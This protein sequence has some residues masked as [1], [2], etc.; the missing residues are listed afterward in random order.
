MI[1]KISTKVDC[2]KGIIGSVLI[3]EKLAGQM[4]SVLRP[5][6]FSPELRP[7]YLAIRKLHQ[8]G[9]PVDPLTVKGELS[10]VTNQTLIQYLEATPTTTNFATYVEQ[11]IQQNK[12]LRLQDAA[13]SFAECPDSDS[14]ET[15]ME[16]IGDTRTDINHAACFD[17]KERWRHFLDQ[18]KGNRPD[19]FKF[20]VFEVDQAIRIARGHYVV[21]GAEPSMGKTALSI[22]WADNV[23]KTYRVGFYSL[24]TDVDGI[25]NR[26]V[27]MLS[28]R[29]LKEF[30]TQNVPPEAWAPITDLYEKIAK[31]FDLIEAAGWKVEDIENHAISKGYDF[32]VVDYLQ[33]VASEPKETEYQTVT[34]TSKHLQQLA[35]KHKIAVFALSQLSRPSEKRPPNMHDLRSSGQIE[36]DADSVVL[37][38][39]DEGD[40]PPETG[41]LTLEDTRRLKIAKQKEGARGSIPL[42][43]NR[44]SQRFMFNQT[45]KEKR[46]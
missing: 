31:S 43:Y 18:F 7:F 34:R 3:D 35:H 8:V 23:A 40:C 37:L 26:Q 14:V 28:G 16:I 30:T 42:N 17:G 11:L 25:T 1:A 21:L 27:A 38:Y 39:Q 22:Q 19:T 46:K 2:E 45:L 13:H 32:I 36:A 6:D 33:L 41:F 10:G 12:L 44:K 24:E 20:G 15:L 4:L 9:T 29:N 5:D